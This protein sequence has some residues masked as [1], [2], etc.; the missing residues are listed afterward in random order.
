[1]YR[2]ARGSSSTV[3]VYCRSLS[4][5]ACNG[6]SRLGAPDIVAPESRKE[7]G[8]LCAR[9]LPSLL[10][11]ELDTKPCRKFIV[12]NC[13]SPNT[14]KEEIKMIIIELSGRP[15]LPASPSFK[16]L[17]AHII[18]THNNCLSFRYGSLGKEI[19][20]LDTRIRH[21]SWDR[22]SRDRQIFLLTDPSGAYE[23]NHTETYCARRETCRM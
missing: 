11:C 18:Y 20:L 10:R 16:I 2:F 1:M 7:S 3:E 23:T 17:F 8:V 4:G 12:L 13:D 5:Y 9:P 19:P 22:R 6:A 15:K 21:T 14:N